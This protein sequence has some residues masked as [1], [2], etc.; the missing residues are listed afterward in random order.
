MLT[1]LSLLV[2]WL[3]SLTANPLC[4]DRSTDAQINC[5]LACP[6]SRFVT[7]EENRQNR[8]VGGLSLSVL[9]YYGS[10][11]FH[12]NFNKKGLNTTLLWYCLD[13]MMYFIK[14]VYVLKSLP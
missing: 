2:L 8:E 1:M 6:I 7:E 10:M 14:Y 5:S 12:Q 9:S 4:G 11:L 3:S 13:I